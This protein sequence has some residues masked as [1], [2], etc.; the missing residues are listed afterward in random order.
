MKETLKIALTGVMG[1]GKSSAA[2][3]LKE[4]GI[5]VID[6]DEINRQLLCRDHIGYQ[7]V[8]AAFLE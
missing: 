3:L 1:A 4:A 7:K 2:A 8:V 6:C 5:L